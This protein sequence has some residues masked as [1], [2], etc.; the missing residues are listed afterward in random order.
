MALKVVVFDVG[1]TLIDE[2]HAWERLADD[3]RVPRFTLMG[4]VGGLA[5][6]GESHERAWELLGVVPHADP[7]SPG[8][9]DFY[10]DAIPCLGALRS[11]GYR[12]GAAGNMPESFE[13]ALRARVDFTGSSRRWGVAK[14]DPA[15]FARLVEEA[16][17]PPEQI[18][19]VGDRVDNDVVPALAAG[20]VAVH[21]KRGPWGHLHEPP[22]GALQ[23]ASL[24]ELPEVLRGA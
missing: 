21:V 15:F 9:S 3:A 2:T 19:Y 24:A 8:G 16:G 13:Q 18:A 20:M 23:V 17:E 11:E 10:R 14:P 5:A 4:L 1:E 22:E 12:L 7:G 6:R